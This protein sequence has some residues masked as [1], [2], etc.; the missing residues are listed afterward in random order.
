MTLWFRVTDIKLV[1]F[2]NALETA[3][4]NDKVQTPVCGVQASPCKAPA[5]LCQLIC[6]HL[7]PE[8]KL[9]PP[10][11]FPGHFMQFHA[12]ETS[13]LLFLCSGNPFCLL[14]TWMSL[15]QAHSA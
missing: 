8:L 1:L 7:L 6:L 4:P 3:D 13:H 14:A 15:F 10:W 9:S 12:S 5:Y 2:F 11:P